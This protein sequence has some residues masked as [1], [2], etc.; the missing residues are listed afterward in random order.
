MRISLVIRKMVV[1]AVDCNPKRWR[2]LTLSQRRFQ[3]RGPGGMIPNLSAH[4][5]RSG[6]IDG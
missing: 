6:M 5:L 3:P 4:A 2:E 1:P